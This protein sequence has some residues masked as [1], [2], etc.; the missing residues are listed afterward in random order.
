[1]DHW[2]H[3]VLHGWDKGVVQEAPLSGRP[4]PIARVRGQ[5]QGRQEGAELKFWDSEL[6]TEVPSKEFWW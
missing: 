4:Y 6:Q 2:G 3:A 5:E 1:M